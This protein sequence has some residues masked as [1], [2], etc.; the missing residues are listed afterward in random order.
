MK[1]L[2]AVWLLF[3]LTLSVFIGCPQALQ[4]DEQAAELLYQNR[5][6]TSWLQDFSYG[7][8]YN[9]N[10][11]YETPDHIKWRKEKQDAAEV[12]IQAIGAK[13]LPVLLD[14]LAIPAGP[15]V[16][17]QSQKATFDQFAKNYGT[18]RGFA[19]LGAKAEPAI[20][21][22]I[23]L[24]A[25]AYDAAH[26]SGSE[27]G[28]QLQEWQSYTTGS[29]LR[30]MGEAAVQSLIEA[31]LNS[32][33]VKIR[34]GAAMALEYHQ[35]AKEVIPSL[36]KALDDDDK[37]VR[38]RAVRSLGDLRQM[39]EIAVPAIARR[40]TDDPE[41][42]VRLYAISALT[43]FGAEAAPAIPA[44]YKATQDPD[45]YVFSEVQ[46]ALKEIKAAANLKPD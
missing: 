26:R 45:P 6:L 8:G 36:I 15:P 2:R 7:Y 18:T 23:Q 40:M 31:L 3:C 35:R 41:V 43:K 5:A 1:G 34:F 21:D 17:E 11:V 32:K 29:I 46:K 25:P 16:A 39:P 4:A 20:P 44:L 33:D 27:P 19:A 12:A 10:A 28:A 24:L 9:P 37:D 42:N 13:A 22:L 38:W 30:G 14:R